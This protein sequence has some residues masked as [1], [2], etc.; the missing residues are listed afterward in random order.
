VTTVLI[1][2]GALTLAVWTSR[3][4]ALNRAERDEPF[5]RADAG[6]PAPDPA[7]FVSVLIP[8]RNESGN[9]VRCIDALL[10]QNYSNLE[11][12][13]VDDRSDDDTARLVREY[14]ERAPAVRLLVSGAL[15]EGWTGKNFAL[16]QG[17]QQARGELLLFL[18]AD[19]A[20]D[21]GALV[22][23]IRRLEADRADMLSLFVRL[24]ST[25]FWEKTVRVLAGAI[26]TVR[27]PVRRVNDPRRPEAFAN[28]QILL[29]RADAYRAIGGHEAVRSALLEDVALA[30]HVKESGRRL[31][32]AYGFDAAAV[33]MY[34]TFAD[35]WRGWTRIY[36]SGFRSDLP[37]LGLAAFALA[38][39]TLMPYVA[40]VWGAASLAGG[41][42][43]ALAW[44]LLAL[45]LAEIAVM[46]SL[47]ARLH[48]LSR[49]DARWALLNP[50]AGLVCLALLVTAAAQCVLPGVIV[51]KDTPY[52]VNQ[53][54]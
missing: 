37:R 12:L 41:A 38:V 3:H 45:S 23:V 53:H 21:P 24:D 33:R 51:W 9:I 40:L 46:V 54:A 27:Y 6:A 17:A 25:G 29:I 5:V 8:A 18:D 4:F 49:S 30:H 10:A 34:S 19:V 42:G 32:M 43:G 50:L 26:L 16:W 47:M 48:A 22:A 52:D 15:S 44:T 14:A 7:P 20:L 39:F 1:I 36:Y 28:G 35:L 31:V 13:V 2:L 11:V